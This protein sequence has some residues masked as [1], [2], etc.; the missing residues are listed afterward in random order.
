MCIVYE[1]VAKKKWVFSCADLASGIKHLV[2]HR[3]DGGN[4]FQIGGFVSA[5]DDPEPVGYFWIV[6]FEKIARVQLFRVIFELVEEP[7]YV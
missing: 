1:R 5:Y 7:F 2:R 3:N 4:Q 6:N